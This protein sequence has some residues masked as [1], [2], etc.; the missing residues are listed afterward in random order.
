VPDYGGRC[1]DT[2]PGTVERLLTG[3]T[4]SSSFDETFFPPLAGTWDRVV[5]VYLD[6]FGWELFERSAGHR[7]F[8]RA[9]AIVRLTSQFPST[10]T[11]HVTTV[12]TGLS[13]G[14][15]GVYEWNVY[16]PA[17]DRLITPLLFSYAGD[18]RRETLRG[19]GLTPHDVF[20][21]A[22]LYQRLAQAG[23]TSHLAQ[24]A[25][26]TPSSAG[27]AL[28]A[29]ANVHAFDDL[30]AG[31]AK[32]ARAVAAT[33]PAYGYL[34]IGA[35]DALM[36]EEGPGSPNVRTLVDLL[37]TT[38]ERRLLDNL[39]SGT[40]V[41]LVSDHGMAPVSLART[42][43]LNVVWPQLAD[44]VR[45]GADGKP[46]APAG[47]PRDVFLHAGERANEVVEG[48]RTR[49]EGRARVMLA[50][51]LVDAG[52]FGRAPGGALARRLGDVAVLP[53]Y[54]EAVYWYE[55]GRFE[56]RWR[57]MHGGLSPQET[58]VPLAAFAL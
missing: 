31:A 5:L 35:L 56:Q 32:L 46:L 23:V 4:S 51:E 22:T 25:A 48:L 2:V 7:L 50:A 27:D 6:A 34:Y 16:E 44:L 55:R 54:G 24:S 14:V 57:G 18:D 28:H 36:H 12:H 40:L 26:F 43:Y 3:A 52:Y 41:V 9:G 45:V 42:T 11:A 47:S 53:E 1:F 37:L 19:S 10:T 21:A 29:G 58:Y 17:L 30:A 13:V 8:R 38:V 15:H 33:A 49:L 39:R 20:P